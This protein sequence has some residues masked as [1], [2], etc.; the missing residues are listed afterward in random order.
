VKRLLVI[1]VQQHRKEGQTLLALTQIVDERLKALHPLALQP[2][3]I[4]QAGFQ[5]YRHP[6]RDDGLDVFRGRQRP[7]LH[8]DTIPLG[9]AVQRHLFHHIHHRDSHPTTAGAAG[10]S[11][12]MDIEFGII[13]W[14]VDDDVRQV[15]EIDS[16]CRDI[17]GDQESKRTLSYPSHD[18]FARLLRKVRA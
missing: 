5:Q 18:L 11:R 6:L 9:D 13:G 16:A 3:A 2:V 7:L 12:A 1:V 15:R 17:G 4:A 10:A 14:L 8:L